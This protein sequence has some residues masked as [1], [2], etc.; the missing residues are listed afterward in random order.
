M[1]YD[2]KCLQCGFEGEISCLI[3]ERDNQFC[4]NC[5]AK[6]KRLI[7][8][9]YFRIPR[10]FRNSVSDEDIFTPI[11]Q[12]VK[13]GVSKREL[14][15]EYDKAIEELRKPPDWLKRLREREEESEKVITG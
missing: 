6:L 12:P 3:A 1:T 9:P 10:S 11:W 7:S 2:Y 4:P 5:G 14:M 8:K 13:Y 15:R